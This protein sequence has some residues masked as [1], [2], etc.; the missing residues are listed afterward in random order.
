M[1]YALAI[2]SFVFIPVLKKISSQA[3]K[4]SLV[5]VSRVRVSILVS[6]HTL[7]IKL[8]VRKHALVLEVVLFFVHSITLFKSVVEVSCILYILSNNLPTFTM[9]NILL[10]CALIVVGF[11][12]VLQLSWAWSLAL[13]YLTLVTNSVLVNKPSLAIRKAL[14]KVACIIRPV[15]KVHPPLSMR[16]QVLPLPLIYCTVWIYF[17]RLWKCSSFIVLYLRLELL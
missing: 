9:G 5:P 17:T 6:N 16:H 11:G 4:L 7:P 14:V 3:F 10:P 8:I 12:L 13:L 1:F 15:G 2:L